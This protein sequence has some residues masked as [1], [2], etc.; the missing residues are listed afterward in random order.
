L[1]TVD[2]DDLDRLRHRHPD[3]LAR[4][5]PAASACLLHE[6]EAL[7]AMASGEAVAG[8]LQATAGASWATGSCANATG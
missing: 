3:V 7:L 5:Q 8:S 2:A 6:N 1:I 4:S